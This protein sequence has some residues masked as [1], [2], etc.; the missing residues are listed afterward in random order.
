MDYSSVNTMDPPS[1][2]ARRDAPQ[3]QTRQ[4]APP[5]I[6][7]HPTMPQ[8][9]PTQKQKGGNDEVLRQIIVDDEAVNLGEEYIKPQGADIGNYKQVNDV[10][11]ILLGILLVDVVVLCL[12]RFLPEIFGQSLNRWYDLFGLNAVLADVGIIAIGFIIARYVYTLW[13]KPKYGENKWSPYMF[14]GVAVVVQLVHDLLF[15]YGIIQQVP[16]GQNA[17]IDVFKDYA[18]AGGAKILFGDA[19]LM[20]FS[21]LMAMTLKSQPLHLVAVVGLVTSYILPYALYAKNQFSIVK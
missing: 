15:Y 13:V 21:S 20:I 9:Q 11:Y 19:L 7:Q 5:P 6:Q 3:V 2:F 10:W 14:T 16:R 1:G 8:A 18:A 12:V 17:M 4:D